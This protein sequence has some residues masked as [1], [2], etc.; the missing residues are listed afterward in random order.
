M[1]RV[2]SGGGGPGER[3]EEVSRRERSGEE[4][5]PLEGR[6]VGVSV[7]RVVNRELSMRSEMESP[8]GLRRVEYQLS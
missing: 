4:G 7:L 5:E 3:R 1:I 2:E 6:R 8:R